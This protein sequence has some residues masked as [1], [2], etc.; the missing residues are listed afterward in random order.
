MTSAGS[1]ASGGSG[2]VGTGGAPSSRGGATGDSGAT[3][4]G[5]SGT[6]TPDGG[7]GPR[8]PAELLGGLGAWH[9]TLPNGPSNSATEIDPPELDTYADAYFELA[10]TGDRVRMVDLFGGSRTSTGTAFART[11]LR[12]EYAGT[13]AL[14]NADWPCKT[15][16]HRMHVKQRIALTPLRKPEMS[17]GQIHD[18]SNDLLEVRYIGPEDADGIG[19]GDGKTDTGK[20]EAHFNNDTAFK[21]LDSAYTVGDVMTLDVSTDGAGSMT[22]QYANL[23]SGTARAESAAFYGSVSGGCYFK[24]GNYH[25]ACTVEDTNGNTNAACK[26]KKWPSG[27][28]ETAPFGQSVL[29]LF[30]LTVQ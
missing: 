1:T 9:L 22:V 4:T 16:V 6:P 20:I 19:T 24:A 14:G 25:Q 8:S 30:E 13:G 2:T 21:V 12:Q 23:T 18:G 28:F 10:D 3:P 5:N 15:S 27:R 29:E 17:I 7:K 26:A 11:E